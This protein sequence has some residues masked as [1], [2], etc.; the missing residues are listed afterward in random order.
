MDDENKLIFEEKNIDGNNYSEKY[1]KVKEY[2]RKLLTQVKCLSNEFMWDFILFN[3][4]NE[5]SIF[6][7]RMNHLICDGVTTLIYTFR[8]SL[9]KF[10]TLPPIFLI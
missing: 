10:V 3:M 9:K 6:Y 2:V 4:G 5:E 7:A 1:E 8:F